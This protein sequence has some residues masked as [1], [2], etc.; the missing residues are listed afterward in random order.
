MP[1]AHT[2]RPAALIY[3]R[4]MPVQV[5]F[6]F[7]FDCDSI[8]LSWHEHRKP[9]VK[10]FGT[11]LNGMLR[12]SFDPCGRRDALWCKPFMCTMATK[13]YSKRQST[14]F[15]IWIQIARSG[16]HSRV[17]TLAAANRIGECGLKGRLFNFD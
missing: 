10:K 13:R 1:L 4:L 3:T 17:A 8:T 15:H 14:V 6:E 9:P 12:L 2:V 7:A 16:R 5:S 11:V